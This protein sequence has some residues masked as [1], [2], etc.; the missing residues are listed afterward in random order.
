MSVN[1]VNSPRGVELAKFSR[2]D[3]LRGASP[4]KEVLWL[5]VR[6]VLFLSCPFSLSRVKCAVLRIFGARVGIGVIIKP[7]V[8]IT[9]PWKLQIGDHVWLGEECWLLNLA[10]I[11]L[12]DNVCISQRALLCTGNHD[13]TKVSF[14]LI[15]RPIV[16]EEGGWIGAG[17][18]VGPGVTVGNHAVLT[19]GS[20]AARDLAPW[21]VFSGNPAQPGRRREIRESEKPQ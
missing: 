12:E 17:A 9:F 20:V 16:V 21:L 19:A 15:T 5:L 7:Q 6:Q 10:P 11:K 13:Y 14:D 1:A 3:F 4:L 2:G 18:F 8:K